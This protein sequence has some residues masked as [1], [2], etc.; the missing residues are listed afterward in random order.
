M[1]APDKPILYAKVGGPPADW[2]NLVIKLASNGQEVR[3]VLEVNAH[4]GWY[5][6]HVRRPDGKLDIDPLRG[7]AKTRKVWRKVKIERRPR[8]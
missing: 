4:A 3:D 5:V 7:T 8:P 1:A 6:Q 2:R